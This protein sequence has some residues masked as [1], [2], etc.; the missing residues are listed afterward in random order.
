ATTLRAIPAAAVAPVFGLC[1]RFGGGSL[2]AG[3]CHWRRRTGPPGPAS[4]FAPTVPPMPAMTLALAVI[5]TPRTAID[6]PVIAAMTAPRP[7]DLDEHL[8]GWTRGQLG[9]GF[10]WWLRFR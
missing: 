6:R 3:L 8:F 9:S 7:P 1:R 5:T 2:A 4:A 10:G